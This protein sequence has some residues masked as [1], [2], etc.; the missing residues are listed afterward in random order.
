[1]L[2][3]ILLWFP[4]KRSHHKVCIPNAGKMFTNNLM[5][6]ATA[7]GLVVDRLWAEKSMVKKK[8][9]EKEMFSFFC[10][11]FMLDILKYLNTQTRALP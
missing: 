8:H 9:P 10:Q 1:M 2:H 11:R 7:M 3:L 6:A 4:L 5:A